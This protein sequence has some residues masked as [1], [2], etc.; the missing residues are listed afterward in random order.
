MARWPKD[1]Q[2]ALIAFYGDP[3]TG[4]P[5]KQ[6]VKVTPPFKMYYDGKPVATLSFH[7]KAAPG[8]LAALNKVWDYYGHDQDT[9]DELGISKTA[10][11]YNPRKVRGSKTKW[12]NHAYGAAIDINAEQNGFNVAG[13]I[14]RPMIAAFKSEGFRWGGD[15]KGRKDPMHFEAC[16]GGEPQRT[17]EEWLA[18]LGVKPLAEQAG[19][20]LAQSSPEDAVPGDPDVYH[21][22]GRLKAMGYNPGGLDGL[23]GG[24]TAGAISGFLNDR[25]IKLAA[26][27]SLAMFKKAL[28]ALR[29]EMAKAESEKFTRPISVQ[30]AA[31]TPDDLTQ[32]LPE[33][34]A[35]QSASFWSKVQGWWSG[36]FGG[37]TATGVVANVMTAKETVD[38]V[39]SWFG[40]TVPWVIGG[41]FVLAVIAIAIVLTRKSAGAANESAD[42]STKAFNESNRL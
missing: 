28:P 23:W 30:R 2:K 12:S 37:V 8:L 34:K 39:K 4:A 29:E 7:K 21:V 35:A 5:G 10:G 13:N 9:I 17:F 38:P 3:G 18:K 25:P 32:V 26:P 40:E 41:V 1:N 6:L 19:P 15:Y 33:V 42:Q 20:P 27:T 36:A 24:I 11:T 14:P 31:A 16:D 22:Q